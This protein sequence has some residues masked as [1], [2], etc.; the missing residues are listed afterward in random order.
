MLPLGVVA[1]KV[2]P[3]GLGDLKPTLGVL[4]DGNTSDLVGMTLGFTL[5]VSLGVFT[6]LLNIASHIEGVPRRLGDGQTEVESNA[7]RNSAETD[8]DTPH[9]VNGQTANTATGSGS[10]GGHQGFLETRS[11]DESD[12]GRRKLTD[13][14]HGKDGS[15]HGASPFRRSESAIVRLVSKNSPELGNLLRSDDGR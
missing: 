6:G 4:D 5:D 15:H 2:L 10:F 14:L 9:L 13:S 3:T 1:A 11:N 8:D 7:S 12:D